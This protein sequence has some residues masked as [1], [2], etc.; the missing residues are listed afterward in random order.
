M[1]AS[2]NPSLVAFAAVELRRSVAQEQAFDD[3]QILMYI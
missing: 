1:V 2:A 3:S